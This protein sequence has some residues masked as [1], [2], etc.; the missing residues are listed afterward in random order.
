MGC[1][2]LYR[3]RPGV[4]PPPRRDADRSRAACS[5]RPVASSDDTIALN[6]CVRWGLIVPAPPQRSGARG[7]AA[8]TWTSVGDH[9]QWF[10]RVAATRK[11]REA[12]P[13]LP[14]LD[15]CVRRATLADAGE[16][17]A[18]AQVLLRFVCQFDRALAVLTRADSRTLAP[19]ER[20][21][22]LRAAAVR[23]IRATARQNNKAIVGA[24][25][26]CQEC[27][28]GGTVLIARRRLASRL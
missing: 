26:R 27:P 2:A 9:R 22:R 4:F 28:V 6:E 21:V 3:C 19:D 1:G 14:L 10:R 24:I 5:P 12:D 23:R 20:H 11:A 8:R 17:A 18:R 15:D 16:L 7:P 25:I 13:V